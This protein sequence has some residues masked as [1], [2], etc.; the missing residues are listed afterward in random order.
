MEP[1]NV[2]GKYAVK[3]LKYETVVGHMP[4]EILHYYSF[5]L[6]S[7]GTMSTMWLVPEKTGEELDWQYHENIN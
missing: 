1:D 7:G 5:V 3:V 6:N 4:R 2:H